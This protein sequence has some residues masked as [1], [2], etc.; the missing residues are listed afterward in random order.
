MA[1]CPLARC[2]FCSGWFQFESEGKGRECCVSLYW[3][4]LPHF[5][6]DFNVAT[7]DLIKSFSW[8]DEMY[9]VVRQ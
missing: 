5:L 6:K 3:W 1:W 8:S 9:V 4:V 7:R 2:H